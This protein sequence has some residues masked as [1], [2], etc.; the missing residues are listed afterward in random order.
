M[1]NP[2]GKAWLNRM[3]WNDLKIFLEV[4]DGASMRAA[5]KKLGV[6]HSKVSRRLETLEA[7]LGIRL[8]DRRSDGFQL[9]DAGKELLPL[10]LQTDEGL[11]DFGRSVT[12]RDDVLEGAVNV[13]IAHTAAVSLFMPL[14]QSFMEEYPRIQIK[15][16]DSAALFDLSRREADVAIRFTDAPPDHLIGRRLGKVHQAAYATPAY[17][18]RHNP[19]AEE[20]T[21]KWVGWGVPQDKPSWIAQSPFPHLGIVGH[22]DSILIQHA[23][24]R[25]GIGIGHFPCYIGD[26]DPQLIR[27]SDPTP[28]MDAWLLSHRDLRAAARMRAFRHYVIGRAKEIKAVLEGE[29]SSK[30]MVG[31]T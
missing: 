10:A 8:F 13:T 31:Q 28:W 11:H 27:L 23:A 2:D 4:A 9:T 15:V 30:G 20:S 22:F 21:A 26:L 25:Q 3:N 24:T 18:E 14:F 17:V 5:A 1:V 19:H 6:S 12:G 7:D 16:S 29:T